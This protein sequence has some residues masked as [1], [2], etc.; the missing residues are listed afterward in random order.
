MLFGLLS[1]TLHLTARQFHLL[2]SAHVYYCA[3]FSVDMGV[4]V[5]LHVASMDRAGA[6]VC[7][8]LGPGPGSTITIFAIKSDPWLVT[9]SLLLELDGIQLD[10]V[11]FKRCLSTKTSGI[12]EIQ[13]VLSSPHG[14]IV[15]IHLCRELV[16]REFRGVSRNSIHLMRR[17][18][19]V[20]T[21]FL[22]LS[23]AIFDGL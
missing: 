11:L 1:S 5:V 12:L 4:C 21:T 20:Q 8:D 2:A 7:T 6:H 17:C 16:H 19:V 18:H 22:T 15:I 9:V 3:F 13:T 10:G 23:R 14:F